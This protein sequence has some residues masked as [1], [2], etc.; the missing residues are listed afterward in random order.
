[1]NGRGI[2]FLP[3]EVVIRGVFRNDS[4]HGKC[5]I[6]LGGK[7][8]LICEFLNGKVSGDALRIELNESQQIYEAYNLR[9]KRQ[10][11][12]LLK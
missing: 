8:M 6:M 12:S 3:N 4:L 7:I 5:Y 10:L 1:M 9:T 2:L 11:S